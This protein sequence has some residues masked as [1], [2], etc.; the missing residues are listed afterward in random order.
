MF[1]LAASFEELRSVTSTA[2]GDLF[3]D[4]LV[5]LTPALRT[6]NAKRE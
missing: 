1:F 6:Q 3:T 2:S 4:R 5:P